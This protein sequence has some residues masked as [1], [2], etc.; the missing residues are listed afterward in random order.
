MTKILIADDEPNILMLLEIVLKDLDAEIITAENGEIAVEKAKEHKPDLI[1]TDVVMPKMNGFEVCRAVRNIPEIAETPIIILSALG[2]EYNKITGFDEG[3]DDYIIKPFNVEELKARANSLLIRHSSKQK[4][5]MIHIQEDTPHEQ[6]VNE[7]Q[8]KEIPKEPSP[9]TINI[10]SIATGNA[11]LDKN[12]YGGLPKGSN[13]LI[14][15]PIGTGKSSFAR[16]FI[17]TGLKNKE[18]CLWVAIDDD[19]KRIRQKFEENIKESTKSLE[20]RSYLRFVDA[21]SWSSMTQPENERFIISGILELNQLTGVIAD[22]GYEIGQT[23]QS[24]KGGRRVIDSISS[25]LINFDLASTQRFLSQIA[26]TGIAFGGA[27]T[28]FIIEEGT[29]EE[30]ILNNIKYIMDGVIEFKEDENNRTMSVRHMKWI[31]HDNSLIKL[32]K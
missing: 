8:K 28:L 21:Y 2:D 20:E 25:L 29:V 1:L 5:K 27:T 16:T 13:I 22:A 7:A 18:K 15:G 14:M 24:K 10:D 26:R 9:E 31:K 23:I 19:P 6:V 3:A 32:I 4:A 12:L 30:K 11:D 17:E